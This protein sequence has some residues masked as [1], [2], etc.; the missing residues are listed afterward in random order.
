MWQRLTKESLILKDLRHNK[1]SSGWG[2][3]SSRHGLDV[4]DDVWDRYEEVSTFELV[5]VPIEVSIFVQA[6]PSMKNYRKKKSP[7][8]DQIGNIVNKKGKAT[9][10]YVLGG[11]VFQPAPPSAADNVYGRDHSSPCSSGSEDSSDEEEIRDTENSSFL[12]K[13]RK[14]GDVVPGYLSSDDGSSDS[15]SEDDGPP[16][17]SVDPFRRAYRRPDDRVTR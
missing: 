15:S 5:T 11:Y 14:G 3:D 16:P 1:N 4:A 9:P 10:E 13:L 2:W 6:H 17:V 12:A 8:F 7:F